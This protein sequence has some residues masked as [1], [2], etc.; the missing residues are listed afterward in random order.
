MIYIFIKCSAIC[1]S[2]A[3]VALVELVN[4]PLTADASRANEETA[5]TGSDEVKAI[6]TTQKTRSVRMTARDGGCIC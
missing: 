4:V 5:R 1:H 3:I 2:D 6:L